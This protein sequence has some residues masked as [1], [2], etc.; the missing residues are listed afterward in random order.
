MSFSQLHKLVTYLMAG[1]GLYALTLGGELGTV[2]SL[3]FALAYVVSFF[4]EGAR[5]REETW[6][7]GWNIAVVGFF[8]L[9]L[10]RFAF[11]AS[12]LGLGLEFAG[13]LQ[14][15]RLFNRR[16]AREHLEVAVLAFLHLLAATVLSTHL[17]CACVF[18]GF[19][20]RPPWCTLLD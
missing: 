12:F 11:G 6:I 17:S 7:R 20:L 9:A 19:V 1:L 13:F 8:A 10:I 16:T 15:S 4:V 3:A 18:V 5:L 14:V 2:P